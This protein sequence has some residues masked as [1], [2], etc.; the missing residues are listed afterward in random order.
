MNISWHFQNQI[1]LES[2]R[3][4]FYCSMGILSTIAQ[5]IVDY[6]Q[7]LFRKNNYVRH[8]YSFT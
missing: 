5:S 2:Q 1:H 7:L 3:S 6:E 4:I 8:P